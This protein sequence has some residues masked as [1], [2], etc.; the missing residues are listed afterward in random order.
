MTKRKQKKTVS[1]RSSV[2]I[3]FTVA[4]LISVII[5]G[6]I[7]FSNWISSTIEITQKTARDINYEIIYQINNYLD[8]S[9]K[10]NEDNYK[11]IENNIID[12]T[13]NEKRN[14][15]LSNIILNYSEYIDSFA[16]ATESGELYG[17]QRIQDGFEF[18]KCDASTEGR[19]L[20]YSYDIERG[21]RWIRANDSKYD[22][23]KSEWYLA[24]ENSIHSSYSTIHKH[25]I[26]EDLV[27]SISHPILNKDGSLRGVISSNI[28][29]SSIDDYLKKLVP[30]NKGTAVIFEEE[31][32]DMVASSM[33]EMN[34]YTQADGSLE[35]SSIFDMNHSQFKEIYE[36]MKSGTENNSLI[37]TRKGNLYVNLSRYRGGGLNWVVLSAI[38][39]DVFL[40]H[41][42]KSIETASISAI[43]AVLISLIVYYWAARNLVKPIKT[44][45]VAAERFSYGDLSQRVKVVRDDEIG[46]IS[47]AFNTIADRMYQLVQNLETNVKERTSELEEA[48]DALSKTKE[49]LYL[50][51]DS[52]AEGIFGI[53][54]E[55]KCTFCNNSSISLLGYVK[56][57]DLLGKR[58]HDLIQ[59]KDLNGKTIPYKA[60]KFYRTLTTGEKAQVAD[61][62]Y[63]KADGTCIE[64]EYYSYPQY[65]DGEIIGAVITFMD[66][67]ERIKSEA[68]IRYLSCHDTLTGLKNR[69]YLE[70]ALIIHDKEDK[71]PISIIFADLN[72]LKLVNDVFGHATGDNLIRRAGN[73]LKKSCR[74]SDIIARVGGD[75]FI[76]LLPNTTADI[77]QQVV[78]RIK[79]ELMKE[80]VN[81]I[82]CSMALGFDTKTSSY[83]DIE[84][85]MVNAESEMYKEKLNL[86]KSFAQDTISNLIRSLQKKSEKEKAH[87]ETVA[88]LCSSMGK[89]MGLP[90]NEVKKLSEA[91]YLH[92][93][94]KVALTEEILVKQELDEHE[95]QQ[96]HLHPVIGYRILNLFDETLDLAPGIYGHHEKWDGTG[97]PKG[98]KGQEIP[99]ISR[100]ISL[101]ESYERRLAR[102]DQPEFDKAREIVFQELRDD[103][104]L[105]FD[106]ELVEKFI[107]MMQV[108]EEN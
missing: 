108:M 27:I 101:V 55:G 16:Y 99:M 76:V 25:P 102:Y 57:S 106:P 98:L 31:T 85:I 87:S 6:H 21:T 15:F 54:L 88:K 68:Q 5:I 65:K 49:E 71:L 58:M 30:S 60:G 73:I 26:L 70:E 84:K 48:N 44:L 36:N 12:M 89:A 17:V 78:D 18:Y 66:I 95:K 83:Q 1:I 22:P 33:E 19:L 64:V 59:S 96:M 97:Y 10:I 34:F 39:N 100:I 7:I 90:A 40:K 42:Y 77:A 91:G 23:R 105:I 29:L 50:I 37:P 79:L 4:M 13:E 67:T 104:G 72:G 3:Y 20:Y 86:R 24:G 28:L 47:S 81:E 63:W 8:S 43:I 45:L 41:V 2:I 93:I 11:L 9:E 75:E 62:V 51:L 82:Q 52:T 80:T 92:D 14:E 103:A 56:Q 53:D 35:R 61:E 94:G 32:G 107:E 74:S 46:K 38:P 69:S